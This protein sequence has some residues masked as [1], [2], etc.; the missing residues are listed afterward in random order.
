MKKYLKF[1]PLITL[2]LAMSVGGTVQAKEKKQAKTSAAKPVKMQHA[3]LDGKSFSGEMGDKGKPA[4]KQDTLVF[5]NGR[6]RSTACDRFGFGSAPYTAKTRGKTT[7]FKAETKNSKGATIQWSGKVTGH[8]AKAT[9]LLR[10]KDGKKTKMWFKTT[11]KRQ[12]KVKIQP[13]AAKHKKVA[14]KKKKH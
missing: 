1:I 13:V 8:E 12:A 11:E 3:A 6:F 5:Q 7:T 9:A 4:D 2:A 10:D 14:A